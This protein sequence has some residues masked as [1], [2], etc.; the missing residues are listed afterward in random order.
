MESEPLI[1]YCGLYCDLCDQRTRVP[2]R[3]AALLHSLRLADFEAWGRGYPG[4]AEFWHLL[5]DL[6]VV[7][8][9]RTCRSGHCGAPDC[10]IRR[11][12]Q[13]K[14]LAV[15]VE[16]GEYPCD[17]VRT[18]GRSEPTL[19]HDGARLREIG[20]EAWVAEQEERRRSGFCYADVRCGNCEIPTE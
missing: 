14:G 7:R 19:L 3:A 15:C 2:E 13:S 16:C 4:F 12:A 20:P 11:C 8:R 9:E 1:A 17:R 10:A 5:A 18:L 6:A